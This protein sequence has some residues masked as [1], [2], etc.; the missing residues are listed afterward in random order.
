MMVRPWTRLLVMA[1]GV[2]AVL[3]C[4]QVIAGAPPQAA[5]LLAREVT[6]PNSPIIVAGRAARSLYGY[7]FITKR[8]GSDSTWGYRASD[9]T[10]ARFRY[11]GVAGDS[12]RVLLELWGGKCAPDDRG[13]LQADFVALMTALVTEDPPPS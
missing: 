1:T 3:G 9:S 10:H 11:R 2:A 7:Q 4:G 13:C 6:V 8:F 12:T 5:P